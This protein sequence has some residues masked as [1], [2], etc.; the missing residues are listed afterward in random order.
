[1]FSNFSCDKKFKNIIL[2]LISKLSAQL[3]PQLFPE[4]SAVFS[5]DNEFISMFEEY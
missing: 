4:A 2:A 1:M 3:F 5:G